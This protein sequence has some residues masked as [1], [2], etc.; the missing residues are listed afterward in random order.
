MYIYIV[1]IYCNNNANN[2]YY[3]YFKS[4]YIE[5]IIIIIS[6]VDILYGSIRET[7]NGYIYFNKKILY[8]IYVY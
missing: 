2:I 3:F 5:Q 1:Y 8:F 6:L 7:K 4:V